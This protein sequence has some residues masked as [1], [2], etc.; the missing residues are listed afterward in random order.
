MRP[1]RGDDGSPGEP[2]PWFT[3]LAV[4]ALS[5]F[6]VSFAM[7][8][9]LLGLGSSGRW[10]GV[11]SGVVVTA[12]LV[13]PAVLMR[14]LPGWRWLAFGTALGLVVGWLVWLGNLA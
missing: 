9:L 14:R 11:L 2:T 5:G 3:G 6:V 1:R 4:T 7:L 13:P 12:G 8:A 10:L